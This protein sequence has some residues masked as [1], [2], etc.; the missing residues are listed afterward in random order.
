MMI[1]DSK[2]VRPVP[3]GRK[4]ERG[5]S[6]LEVLIVVALVFILGTFAATQ[7]A[8]ARD[9]VRLQGAARQVAAHIEKA[10]LDSIRRHEVGGQASVQFLNRRTYRVIM[11][12]NATGATIQRDFTLPDGVGLADETIPGAV[13][14]NWRGR[15]NGDFEFTLR[16]NAR[17]LEEVVRVTAAGEVSVGREINALAAPGVTGVGAGDGVNNIF[18]GGG[19]GGNVGGTVGGGGGTVTDGGG[20]GGTVIGGGTT[21]GGGGIVGGGGGT[22]TDGGGTTT[23]G[24][25]TT[26]GGGGTTTGGGGTTTG[27]GGGTTG[28]VPAPTCTLTSGVTG[29]SIKKNSSGTFTVTLNGSTSF[30]S[31]TSDN[32][33][34][35]IRQTSVSG[36]NYTFTVTSVNN[37]KNYTAKMTLVSACDPNVKITIDVRVTA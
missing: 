6:V 3:C 26:T 34:V 7:V 33:S 25:G 31:V 14:F 27:G 1:Q 10:R 5:L 11:D 12:F 21:G 20:G 4:S 29:I 32:A 36:N 15:A 28:G 24:G 16:N 35:T 8:R 22:I 30:S 9:H 2:D 18:P 13:A 17:G 23:D 37:N 19:A